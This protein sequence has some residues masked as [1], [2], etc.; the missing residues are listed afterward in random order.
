MVHLVQYGSSTNPCIHTVCTHCTQC[1]LQIVR[2]VL[3][4]TCGAVCNLRLVPPLATNSESMSW[5]YSTVGAVVG[6]RFA[7]N[8]GLLTMYGGAM[9]LSQVGGGVG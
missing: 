4:Q 5:G 7:D 2:G 9:A 1:R 6:S 3:K 8:G